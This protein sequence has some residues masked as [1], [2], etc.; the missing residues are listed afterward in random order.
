MALEERVEFGTA[1]Q[2]VTAD[3]DFSLNDKKELKKV[4]LACGKRKQEGFIGVDEAQVGEVDIVHDLSQYPWPFED[5]SIYAFFCSHYV[6]HCADLIKFMEEVW[7]CLMVGGTIEIHAPYYTS[8][9]AWQDPTHV[10]A[11]SEVTF[12]YFMKDKAE[13][14]GVDHYTGKCNFEL[15]T[16]TYVLNKEFEGRADEAQKWAMKHYFNV[17]DDIRVILRKKAIEGGE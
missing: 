15:V 13:Q 16:R 5:E 1:A 8:V 14:M 9:R 7:R 10:R 6:E 17:V 3:E 4:D 2:M 11:I 12:D